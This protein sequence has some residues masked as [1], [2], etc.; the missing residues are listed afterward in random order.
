M[1][2]PLAVVYH[3]EMLEHRPPGLEPE[4]RDYHAR[5]LRALLGE[6]V[7]SGPWKHPER[8]ERL[9]AMLETARQ[10]DD[11]RIAWPVP[12]RADDEA[13]ARVHT[14]AHLRRLAELSG[15]NRMLSLDTTAVS[16]GSVNA[17]RR[18]A[19][20]AMTAVD[21]VCSGD[22]PTAFALVRPP[23]HHARAAHYR[24][25]CLINN[26][27]V[28]ARHAQAAHGLER[29]LIVD[30]DVHHGDGTESIFESE[31]DVLFFDVHRAAPFYPGSGAVENTG[32][33]RG[34]GAT[35]NV[36]LPEGAGDLAVL[37]AFDDI[38]APAVR[39]F[40]PQLILV[41]AGF[42]GTREH[43]ACHWSTALYAHLSR[44]LL[45]LA[46]EYCSGRLAMVLEGGYHVDPMRRSLEQCL[47]TLLEPGRELPSVQ[48]NRTGLPA[49]RSAREFFTASGAAKTA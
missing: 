38:L 20:A 12:P 31:P 30:W 28:A 22:A 3:E 6:L 17:A 47:R 48:R 21:A 5:K 11:G 34:R 27:A 24:G 14:A 15:R 35:I 18:A 26:I 19:G 46:E 23:G 33:G 44:R 10:I 42:D 16:P 8:P 36:P 39:R 25:F 40:R 4:M 13:L 37:S 9:S 29:I 41:S 7:T 43:L 2:A 49:V 45:G 32:R 1:D